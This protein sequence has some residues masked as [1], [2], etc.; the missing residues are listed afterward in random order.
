MRVEL[1]PKRLEHRKKRMV[2]H[3]VPVEENMS[4]AEWLAPVEEA[5]TR[6]TSDPL[7]DRSE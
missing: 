4:R 2:A 6:R 5:I 7:A 3:D 1:I